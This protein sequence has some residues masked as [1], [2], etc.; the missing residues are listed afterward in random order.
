MNREKLIYQGQS[1]TIEWFFSIKGE[2]PALEYYKSLDDE[3]RRD[4]LFLVKRMGD[5]GK[6]LNKTK[7]N[8]EGDQIYAFKPKP[9]RFL[10]FFYTGKKIIITHAF[11]KSFR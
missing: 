10:C 8:Y 7:F 2:S 1:F 4:F 3:E 11:C 6:I 9:H 5:S